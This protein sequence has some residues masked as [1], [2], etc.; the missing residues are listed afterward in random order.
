MTQNHHCGAKQYPRTHVYF[1]AGELQGQHGLVGGAHSLPVHHKLLNPNLPSQV[2]RQG[3]LFGKQLHT[4]LA[5]VV[6][7]LKGGKG[8]RALMKPELA[9]GN[10]LSCI[11]IIIK[12]APEKE[13]SLGRKK[14]ASGV[15]C[16]K[17]AVF[18]KGLR[19]ARTIKGRNGKKCH[20]SCCHALQVLRHE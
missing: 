12:Q 20:A 1:T 19:W 8:K 11:I 15:L 14:A 3:T 4:L 2:T 5:T 16:E 18:F 13:G 6:C 17:G 7:L 9:C 10:L